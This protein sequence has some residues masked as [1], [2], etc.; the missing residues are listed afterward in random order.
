MN[1]QRLVNTV[2]KIFKTAIVKKNNLFFNPKV[3]D[4]DDM[5]FNLEYYRH[6]KT[7]VYI[8]KHIYNVGGI[9]NQWLISSDQIFIRK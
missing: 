4:F 9:C 6:I 2:A 7:V 1:K 3:R 5:Y 8:H